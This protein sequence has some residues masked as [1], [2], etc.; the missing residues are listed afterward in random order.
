MYAIYDIYAD[1]LGWCQGGQWGAIV[2]QSHESRLG[3]WFEGPDRPGT[4]RN[5]PDRSFG[6]WSHTLE[7]LIMHPCGGGHPAS[8]FF[9][10]DLMGSFK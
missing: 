1:Q 4:V 3:S 10:R 7:T 9:F 8:S 2:W 6:P 5:G